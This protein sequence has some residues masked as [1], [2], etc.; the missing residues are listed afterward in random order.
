MPTP[1]ATIKSVLSPPVTV[2]PLEVP[3]CVYIEHRTYEIQLYCIHQPQRLVE[4]I[5][6]TTIH[7]AKHVLNYMQKKCTVNKHVTRGRLDVYEKQYNTYTKQITF[8]Q[9]NTMNITI[10]EVW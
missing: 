7:V 6:Y 4:E 9:Q 3:V 5:Q 2:V 10:W 8:P 1:N